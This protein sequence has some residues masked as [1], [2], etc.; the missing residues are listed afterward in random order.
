M[1]KLVIQPRTDYY[2]TKFAYVWYFLI[3][4][5]LCTSLQRSIHF[6]YHF[7]QVS[8]ALSILCAFP[9]SLLKTLEKESAF[10]RLFIVCITWTVWLEMN[11][12][13][14]ER[15]IEHTSFVKLDVCKFILFGVRCKVQGWNDT[16]FGIFRLPEASGEL[17]NSP[18]FNI[19]FT[20]SKT[21]KN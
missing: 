18:I 13:C 11:K 15:K 20:S 21:R 6:T 3:F 10:G 7:S 12:R 2:S 19:T 5:N 14:S 17:V 9:F 8:W 16:I 1:L 4:R